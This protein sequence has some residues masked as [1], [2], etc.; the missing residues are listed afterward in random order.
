MAFVFIL[1]IKFAEI[2]GSDIIR[3]SVGANATGQ[4]PDHRMQTARSTPSL[5][6]A[7]NSQ[8]ACKYGRSMSIGLIVHGIVAAVRRLSLGTVGD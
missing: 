8:Q 1:V 6:A 5:S 3:V 4:Q 2:T 7:C